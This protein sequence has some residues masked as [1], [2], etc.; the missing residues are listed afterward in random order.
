M[1]GKLL[2]ILVVV[3]IAAPAFAHHSEAAEYDSTKPV[4]IKG[5][6]L[7][8]DWINP[9]SW[10]YIEVTG[11][12]GKVAT[13]KAEALPPNGLY[14][15]GWRRDSLKVGEEISIDGYLAKDG[16]TTMWSRSVTISDGRKM[17]AGNADSAPGAPAAAKQ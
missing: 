9:H 10:V 12:G 5:K 15:Q 17:F 4:T 13:W 11:D 6:F 3:A 2:G 16:S 8:M 1:T 14:R 7:K